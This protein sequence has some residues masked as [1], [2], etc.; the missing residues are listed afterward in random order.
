MASTSSLKAPQSDT[1]N[2]L[3]FNKMAN[4]VPQPPLPKTD[5]F[6]LTS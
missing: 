6:N 5:I 1:S 3:F 4:A 2:P